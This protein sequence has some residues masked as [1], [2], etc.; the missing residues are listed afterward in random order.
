MNNYGVYEIRNKINRR[1]NIGKHQNIEDRFYSHKKLLNDN[2]HYNPDLQFDWN[3]YGEDNFEFNIIKTI[4]PE[5]QCL[6][7]LS[8][9]EA[10][11]IFEDCKEDYRNNVL[12]NN[13][14][15][16][17]E[18]IWSICNLLIRENYLFDF[19]RVQFSGSDK[20]ND[21]KLDFVIYKDDNK[22]VDFVLD[23]HNPE[24]PRK[25]DQTTIRRRKEYALKYG[26]PKFTLLDIRCF[27]SD[28][29]PDN[30]FKLTQHTNFKI[31]I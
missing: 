13:H 17:D 27:Y 24:D 11:I 5:N 22:E 20:R 9:L 12:Y 10:K 8:Y 21:P 14:N 1:Y 26:V 31:I 6:S 29:F 7:N 3:L 16:R 19:S 18:I 25:Y 4:K 28:D 30:G 2:E 15:K 23:I